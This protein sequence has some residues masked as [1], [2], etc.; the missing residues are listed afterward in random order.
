MQNPL[1][2]QAGLIFRRLKERHTRSAYIPIPIA[3]FSADE[4]GDKTGPSGILTPQITQEFVLG[5]KL[6]LNRAV[7]S[8]EVDQ[9]TLL[10]QS[11]RFTLLST[12]RQGYFEVLSAQ[13]ALK[14]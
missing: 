1:L 5:G 7:A 4:L 6:T 12:I 8:R 10:L 9:T 2:Q 14:F 13:R 3:S 11:Q